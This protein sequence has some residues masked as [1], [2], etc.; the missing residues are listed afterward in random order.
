MGGWRSENE[1]KASRGEERRD[2]Q[3]GEKE[4]KRRRE[5]DGEEEE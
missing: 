2:W 4:E 1:R 3:G 5:G